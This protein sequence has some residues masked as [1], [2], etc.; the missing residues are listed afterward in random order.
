MGGLGEPY[1]H[2]LISP[3]VYHWRRKVRCASRTSLHLVVDLT[4]R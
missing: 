3:R 1:D 4:K 2:F